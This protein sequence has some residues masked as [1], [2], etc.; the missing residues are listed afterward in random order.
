MVDLEVAENENKFKNISPYD[1]K[2]TSNR[3][4]PNLERI[5]GAEVEKMEGLISDL[6]IAGT[7]I[8]LGGKELEKLLD[9]IR[10]S[11]NND[12]SVFEKVTETL[13]EMRIKAQLAVEAINNLQTIENEMRF[14]RGKR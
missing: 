7:V 5:N 6:Q 4:G 10:A 8:N 13:K 9:I 11:S 2:G 1:D 3:T 14:E 12:H